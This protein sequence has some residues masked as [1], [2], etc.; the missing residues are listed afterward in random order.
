MQDIS[1]EVM[2]NAVLCYAI[3]ESSAERASRGRTYLKVSQRGI[4][5]SAKCE[6]YFTPGLVR[7][8]IKTM[9]VLSHG[10]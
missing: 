6:K 10:C 8:V 5:S 1:T 2:D 9:H 3:M 7:E 4:P